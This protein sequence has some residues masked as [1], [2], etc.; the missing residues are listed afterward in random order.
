MKTAAQI[1]HLEI[2]VP[3]LRTTQS[4]QTY[5]CQRASDPAAT[6]T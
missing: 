5:P 2:P 4:L 1:L 3:I 6:A